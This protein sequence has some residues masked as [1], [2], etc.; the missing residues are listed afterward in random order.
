MAKRKR[1][2]RKSRVSSIKVQPEETYK[3][4]RKAFPKEL[5]D[6]FIAVSSTR[7]E[8]EDLYEVY[9]NHAKKYLGN[10][11]E[12][13]IEQGRLTVL[14]SRATT[15]LREEQNGQ[16]QKGSKK[17]KKTRAKKAKSKKT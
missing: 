17:K 13:R 5:I 4:Q 15:D 3:D 16:E 7:W 11:W 8:D 14:L 1:R 2:K 6:A 9:V 10:K 12:D